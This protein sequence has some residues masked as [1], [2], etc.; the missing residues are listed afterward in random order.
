[1]PGVQ[2][3]LRASLALAVA[4]SVAACQRQPPAPSTDAEVEAETRERVRLLR[5]S[6]T[7]SPFRGFDF[8]DGTWA[9]YVFND[10]HTHR[11]LKGALPGTCLVLRDARKLEE[12]LGAMHFTLPE[13][14]DLGTP[15]SRLVLVHEGRRV[16][17]TFIAL[18]VPK[19][20]LQAPGFGWIEAVPTGSLLAFVSQFEAVRKPEVLPGDPPAFTPEGCIVGPG[21]Q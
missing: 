18:D 8:R 13:G 16:Y 21:P 17:E 6:L 14:G 19:E 3:S 9:A 20:G 12:G 5:P 1:M 10:L 2:R 11:E 15:V 4:T 7:M